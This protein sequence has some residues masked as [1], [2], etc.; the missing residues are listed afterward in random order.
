MLV[1]VFLLA[2]FLVGGYVYY[3]GNFVTGGRINPITIV[4]PDNQ[5]KEMRAEVFAENLTIP[6]SMEFTSDDRMLVTERTGA[7]RIILKGKL[8]PQPLH[9]FK[10]V[11]LVGEAGLMGMARHPEYASNK[12]LYFCLAYEKNGTL[13]NKIV[14][15]VDGGARLSGIATIIDDIPAAEFHAGCRIR[16]GPDKKLYITTGD[17]TERGLAQ[18]HKSLAGKILRY[19]DDGSVPSDNPFSGS[20]VY[21]FGHRN[22]Q[23]I[24]WHPL[25]GKLYQTEH[26]PTGFDGPGGGDEV[27]MIEKGANYGWPIVSHNKSREGLVDPLLVMTPAEAPAS[28]MFYK[29]DMFPEW[30]NSFFFGALKGEGLIRVTLDAQGKVGSVEK[31]FHQEYGRIRDVVE[32]PDGSL[33]FSTSNKD[34]RGNPIKEDDRI[35]RISLTSL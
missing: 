2:A 21:S 11:K 24:D 34:G 35:I 6:W 22:P 9:E 17:T 25:T 18:D 5:N 33:Y 8:D 19:N 20:P 14:G 26:G 30:Q 27:N 1:F 23:G 4:K 7:V 3:T 15:A 29:G 28:G 31:L 32:G 13:T 16:F 12:K 10:E